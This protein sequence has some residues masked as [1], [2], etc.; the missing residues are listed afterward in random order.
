MARQTP[1]E[2]VLVVR[3]AGDAARLRTELA[4]LGDVEDVEGAAPL[5]QVSVR[6]H[7]AR[8]ARER[9]L[10]QVKEVAWAEP[11][12]VDEQGESHVPTGEVSIRFRE[13]LSDSELA[14]FAADHGLRL[15][16]RNEFVPEQA[17]FAPVDARGTYLPDLTELLATDPN[18]TQAW[19]NTMSRYQRVAS[20]GSPA[21]EGGSRSTS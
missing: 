15:E 2:D 5:L 14:S 9:L 16:R 3:P 10:E 17:V 1:S 4:T 13:A 20:E 18:V 21:T 7:D 19:A 6:D 11:L 8:G 12:L